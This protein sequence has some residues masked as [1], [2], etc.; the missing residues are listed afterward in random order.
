REAEVLAEGA[1]HGGEED[2]VLALRVRDQV[3][4]HDARDLAQRGQ[5]GVERRLAAGLERAQR[6]SE[7]SELPLQLDVLREQTVDRILRHQG[8]LAG[9]GSVACP[10][11]PG[12]GTLTLDA[13]GRGVPR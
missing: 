9:R 12:Q 6:V 2:L 7:R 8:L 3:P 4:G 11:L 5:R 13:G 1:L 10:A